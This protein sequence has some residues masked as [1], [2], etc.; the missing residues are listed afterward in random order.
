MAHPG[1]THFSFDGIGT[2][3][4]ISTPSRLSGELRRGLLA[5]V[6]EYDAAWS[7]FRPD[8][9]IADAART[10]G[11]IELPAEGAALGELYG[12]LYRLTEGAMTPLIGGSLERLGYDATYTLRPGGAPLP[13]PRWEDALD[14]QGTALTTTVPAVIDVGAAGKGQLADLLSARLRDGG[15][16]GHFID[17]SGDLLDPGP[18]PVV[19]ALE[20]PYDPTRAIGTVQLGAGALCASAANRRAWATG[21]IMS[22]TAPRELRCVPLSPAGPWPGPRWWPMRWPLRCSLSTVRGWSRSS[23]APGSR[24]MRTGT[25]NIQPTSKGPCSHDCHHHHRP[26]LEAGHRLGPAHDVPAGAVGPGRPGRL[27]PAA[28]CA[29]LV[30]VRAAG[31]ARPTLP[32]A[33]A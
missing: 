17:A 15:C 31:N 28:Q 25:R 32:C 33:L 23:I 4:E 6:E 20:H 3:W 18:D 5:T 11:R 30:D 14:W 8:S 7:R 13:A 9:L 26:W 12:T 16:A 10:P 29:G 19:V 24:C 27:Q 22:W 1:W 21:S 2:R